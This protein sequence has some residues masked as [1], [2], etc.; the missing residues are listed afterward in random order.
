MAHPLPR[1]EWHD[2]VRYYFETTL[3]F[4]S[5]ES[6]ALHR[7]TNV[8]RVPILIV[9]RSEHT[10]WPYARGIS[11]LAPASVDRSVGCSCRDARQDTL[12]ARLCGPLQSARDA[13]R[14]HG[15]ADLPQMIDFDQSIVTRASIYTVHGRSVTI[16]LCGSPATPLP[17]SHSMLRDRIFHYAADGASGD[18]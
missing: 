4:S 6:A 10:V 14:I 13:V 17:T 8:L 2:S 5:D 12:G 16:V 7:S 1:N 9:V 15:R 11:I 3:T 18:N